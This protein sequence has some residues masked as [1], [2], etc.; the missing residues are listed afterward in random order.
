MDTVGAALMYVVERL[1]LSRRLSW[2]PRPS[3][4][5]SVGV[6][7]LPLHIDIVNEDSKQASVTLLNVFRMVHV[8]R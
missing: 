2:R 4:A 3:I 5:D 1:S 7:Y 6:T 8:C